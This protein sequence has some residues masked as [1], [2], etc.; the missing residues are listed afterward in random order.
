MKSFTT[1]LFYVTIFLCCSIFSLSAQNESFC[2]I[3]GA[4]SRQ[5]F[6]FTSY[7]LVM[8]CLLYQVNSLFSNYSFT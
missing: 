6:I 7:I 5:A 4:A 8:I 3:T 1:K 2:A